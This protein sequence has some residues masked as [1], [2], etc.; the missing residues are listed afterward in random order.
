LRAEAEVEAG[1]SVRATLAAFDL[2]MA[3][4]R[5]GGPVGW[6]EAIRSGLRVALRGRL[7]LRPT[8]RLAAHP[9][10]FVDEAVAR[11]AW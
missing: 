10:R 4:R 3:Q 9:E 6:D 2:A 1:P 5:L 7:T 8:H 11:L